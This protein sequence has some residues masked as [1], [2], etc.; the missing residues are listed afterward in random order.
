[1]LDVGPWSMA[2][3]HMPVSRIPASS[4][5]YRLF[6]KTNA[7]RGQRPALL[8]AICQINKCKQKI[9]ASYTLKIGTPAPAKN[10][11][12]QQPLRME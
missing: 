12:N 10:I 2:A 7:E 4:I 8:R 1:M 11:Y 9:R 5:Q 6:K 3:F